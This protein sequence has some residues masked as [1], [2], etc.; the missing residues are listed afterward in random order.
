[1]VGK[2]PLFS[3]YG[4][5]SI[6][7]TLFWGMMISGGLA[8]LAGAVDLFGVHGRMIRG[9]SAGYGWNGI[10]IALIARNH[11]L[12]VIPSALFFAWLDSGAQVASLMSDLTPEIARMIQGIIFYGI[13]AQSLFRW[14]QLRSRGQQT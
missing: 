9:F 8:G 2:N 14:F 12:L 4:G 3:K 13:T 1:M 11:P 6:H 5:I 7:R 10:A